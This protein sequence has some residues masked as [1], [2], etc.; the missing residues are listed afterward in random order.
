[1]TYELV[2]AVSAKFT[3]IVKLKQKNRLYFDIF[4][5]YID[6]V[7]FYRAAFISISTSFIV[8]N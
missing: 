6:H 8:K 5:I 2:L 7:C 4:V 1:M 3:E